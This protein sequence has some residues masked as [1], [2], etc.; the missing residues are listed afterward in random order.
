M[1]HLTWRITVS[2][3]VFWCWA[4]WGGTEVFPPNSALRPCQLV[5]LHWITWMERAWPLSLLA[6]AWDRPAPQ[7]LLPCLCPVW[8]SVLWVAGT[9]AVAVAA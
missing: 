2:Q 5:S 3:P 1:T 4:G 6:Q 7:A 8:S 9:G